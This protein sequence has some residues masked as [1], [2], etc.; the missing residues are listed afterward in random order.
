MDPF[1]AAL[2]GNLEY[3][4]RMVKTA[5]T[6][7][8]RDYEFMSLLHRACQGGH[9]AVAEWLIDDMH[10]DVNVHNDREGR[11]PLSLAAMH[12]HVECVKL[13]LARGAGA[14]LDVANKRRQTPLALALSNGHN[15]IAEI[16]LD[17]GAQVSLMLKKIPDWVSE[18]V[19]QRDRCRASVRA[20][21]Q[22]QR[23]Q[24]RS[25]GSNGRDV[26][27]LVAWAVWCTRRD[28]GAWGSQSI[29]IKKKKL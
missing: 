20:V 4:Q 21:L 24:S 18:F 28:N 9:A 11:T 6:A 19:A 1:Q 26:L 5:S 3:I 17:C 29:S 22:L 14:S 16:L 23:R 7:R 25:I 15:G 13:L 8:A 10:L 12:G 2:S 27:S